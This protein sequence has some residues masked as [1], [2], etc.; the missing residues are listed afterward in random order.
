M[1]GPANYPY[2]YQPEPANRPDG[3]IYR[4]VFKAGWDSELMTKEQADAALAK[5]QYDKIASDTNWR[6]S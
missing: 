6:H 4:V 3:K 5:A 2:I 1:K